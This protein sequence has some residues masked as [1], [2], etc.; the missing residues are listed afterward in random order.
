MSTFKNCKSTL[1]KNPRLIFGQHPNFVMY[2][3]RVIVDNIRNEKGRWQ[4]TKFKKN[5]FLDIKQFLLKCIQ[6]SFTLFEMVSIDLLFILDSVKFIWSL[7][8]STF[9]GSKTDKKFIL[10]CKHTY[11]LS[12]QWY[13]QKR[14][15]FCLDLPKMKKKG[16]FIKFLVGFYLI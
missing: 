8:K 12:F 7:E 3:K 6:W 16:K 1:S 2:S 9:F 13:I 11:A 14:R 15:N 5:A 10:D 4:K